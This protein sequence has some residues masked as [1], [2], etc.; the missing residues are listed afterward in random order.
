MACAVLAALGACADATPDDGTA[1]DSALTGETAAAAPGDTLPTDAPGT[2]S[3]PAA[4][5]VIT[6]D[7]I[8]RARR[9]MS[10]GELR[11][12]LPPSHVVG[13]PD[14]A[15]MVDI[16]A[17]PVT[18]AGDTLYRLIFPAGEAISDD[19]FPHFVMTTHLRARTQDGVGPGSTLSDAAQIYGEPSLSYS[20]YD[21]SREY[22][23]FP[24]QPDHIRFRVQP[25][26]D[27]MF[28][29]SYTTSDEYNTTDEYD[30]DAQ[31]WMVFVDLRIN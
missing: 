19:A 9:G 4:E 6:S 16:V 18:A 12:V 2:P 30:R 8:G 27:A 31:I 5:L 1:Q 7:G 21:E 25:A 13:A 11:S 26:V 23:E 3:N 29:G 20:I 17:I 28:A 14:D 24:R 15:F 22:A 10:L